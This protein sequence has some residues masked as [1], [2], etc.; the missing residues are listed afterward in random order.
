[1]SFT[2]RNLKQTCTF[3][4]CD[5]DGYGGFVY[6]APVQIRCRWEER[7]ELFRS[8]TGEELVSKAVVF[9]AEDVSI[10]GYL[11]LGDSDALDPTTLAGADRIQRFN[12]ITS[13]S[14]MQ[15]MRVAYL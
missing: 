13:L 15:L 10:G 5:S 4:A 11:Y 1:M 7:G 6:S 9:V 14:S 12:R 3:W 8:V 2:T